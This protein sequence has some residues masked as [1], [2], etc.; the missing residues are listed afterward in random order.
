MKNQSLIYLNKKEISDMV[1]MNEAIDSMR[2]AF[3]QLSSGMAK[4]PERM[5]L[6]LS[7][8]NATSLIMPAYYNGSPYYCVKIVS[9]NYSNPMKG[10]PLIHGTVQVFDAQEGKHIA[11]FDG[12]SITAI[13]T[14][15]ASGLA[16]D[17]LAKKE[18]DIC[19][20][21]G[22]GIQASSHLKAMINV[23]KI[24]KFMIFSRSEIHAEK[25]CK[26]HSEKVKCEIGSI[27]KL[28]EADIVCTT[29]PSKSP[30]F[31]F[32]NLK[33]GCH[34][35]VIGSHRPR[36]REVSSD[37]V[38]Q[39]KIIVDHLESCKKE[40]GDLIIPMQEGK[41]SFDK[42]HA[43]LGQIADGELSVRRLVNQTTL[44]KSVGNAIQDLAMVNLLMKKL[45]YD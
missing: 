38:I 22:T 36:M 43:E 27:E 15:A 2:Y 8:N 3:I 32:N 44:F 31:E 25:F 37:I 20:I 13:R 35:N 21:F 11:S 19:A 40:A 10:L 39:S 17:L 41:W 26:T 33:T 30:L 5:R 9:V 16:T 34:L 7:D 1:S 45:N 24:Q 4:V 14:A 12:E 6:N 28:K 23:R 29:T 18:V 42:I